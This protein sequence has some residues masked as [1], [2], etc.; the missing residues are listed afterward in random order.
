MI[1]IKTILLIKKE[2]IKDIIFIQNCNI[3]HFPI[4]SKY[5]MDIEFMNRRQSV[6]FNESTNSEKI[7]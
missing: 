2:E 3:P 4:S 7:C 1:E 5:G 6:T